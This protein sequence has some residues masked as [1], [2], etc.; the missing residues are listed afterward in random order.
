[1]DNII[2]DR[3]RKRLYES[4]ASIASMIAVLEM[5]K[6]GLESMKPLLEELDEH[7]ETEGDSC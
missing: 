1:M 7:K 6:I 5:A 4:I 3:I 2:R